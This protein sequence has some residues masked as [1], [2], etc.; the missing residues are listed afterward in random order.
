MIMVCDVRHTE[1]H[2]I[3]RIADETFRVK[4]YPLFLLSFLPSASHAQIMSYVG[5]RM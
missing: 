3:Y 1:L 4:N 2:R 5:Q